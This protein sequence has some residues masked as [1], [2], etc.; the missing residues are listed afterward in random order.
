[1]QKLWAGFVFGALCEFGAFEMMKFLKW[2][3]KEKRV[4]LSEC[5]ELAEKEGVP[6]EE[7]IKLLQKDAASGEVQIY[8]RKGMDKPKR[9]IPKEH[10]QD[11]KIELTSFRA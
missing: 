11:H 5:L 4:S 3:R 1:V 2:F 6:P 9:K 8:G 10:W 7:F